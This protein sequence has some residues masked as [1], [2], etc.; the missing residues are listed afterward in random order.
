MRQLEGRRVVFV[1]LSTGPPPPPPPRQLTTWVCCDACGKWRK[2][3][4]LLGPTLPD[5]WKCEDNVD[6][7]YN[8]CETAQEPSDDQDELDEAFRS[9]VKAIAPAAAPAAAPATAPAAV[10]AA[11]PASAM[12]VEPADGGGVWV[13]VSLSLPE[14]PSVSKLADGIDRLF[15]ECVDTTTTTTTTTTTRTSARHAA[16]AAAAGTTS[17]ARK[18]YTRATVGCS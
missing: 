1:T 6:W 12:A 13:T 10:P 11:A 3:D 16:A 4:A 9:G 2:V 5:T 7:K 15:C 8:S 18:G 17:T 14:Q